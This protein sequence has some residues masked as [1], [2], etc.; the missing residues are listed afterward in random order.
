[1]VGNVFGKQG[2][3]VGLEMD[4]GFYSDQDREPLESFIRRSNLNWV[5][6][7]SVNNNSVENMGCGK[8]GTRVKAK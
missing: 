2:V 1:M 6:L 3:F 5:G 4:V 7:Q 8:N